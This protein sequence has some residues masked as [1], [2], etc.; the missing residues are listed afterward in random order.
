MQ[1]HPLNSRNRLAKKYR[2]RAILKNG[3]CNI[4]QSKLSQKRLRFLQDI[5]TTFVDTQWRWTLL[6]FGLSFI[7][8]W[9]FFAVIWWLIA[10][11]HGDFEESHLPD[12]QPDSGWKPCVYN[13]HT[14]TSCFL[15]SIETQHTI[16]YGVRT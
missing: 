10:F 7:G 14:F 16:G 6:T 9:L 5:F 4:V 15:F 12:N 13:I 8:S 2:K 11:T 1:I 3:E